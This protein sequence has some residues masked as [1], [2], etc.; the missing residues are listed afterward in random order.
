[1][2]L[3]RPELAKRYPMMNLYTS[4]VKQAEREIIGREHEMRKIK[5][6]MMRPELCNVILLAEAGTGKSNACSSIVPVADERGYIRLGDIKIG[7]KV[8]DENGNPV[9]VIGVF[10]QG[11]QHAYDV[12]FT[13]GSSVIC[14]DE[15]LWAARTRWHHYQ[16][17]PYEVHTL[18]EMMNYGITRTGHRTKKGPQEMKSWYVPRNRAVQ[19]PER[20]F[21]IHPYV[22]GVLLGDGCLTEDALSVSSSDEPVIRRVAEL[23][24]A[25][26]VE[27]SEFCY[28]WKFLKEPRMGV[29][30]VSFFHT[31]EMA[32]LLPGS[33]LFGYKSVERRIPEEYFLGSVEQRMELLH[34]LMDTDGSVSGSEGRVN[35]RFS[36]NN[37]G[38]AADIQKLAASLGYRTSCTTMER[39][40]EIHYNTEYNIYFMVDD[41]TVPELFW[42]QRHKDWVMAHIR[43]DK[44]F[45]RI[46]EDIAI[47]EVIDL[48]REEEMVCIY[49]DCPSHLFQIGECHIVTHNTAL[50][51]GTMIQD[52]KRKYIEVDLSRMLADLS[53]PNEMAT[54]LKTLFDEVSSYVKNHH[55]EIVLFIDE[56]HQIVQLSAAAVEALKPLLADSG[57]RG[58]RVIAAT[59]YIEFQQFVAPNLPLVERLQRINVSQPN[60]ETTVAILK[61][62]AKRYGVDHQFYND[63]VYELIYE[64]TNRYIPASSQPR[65]SIRMMDSM[66]GYHRSEGRRLDAKLLAD[67]IYESEGVNVAFRVDATSI[68]KSLDKRVLS[69]TLATSVIEQ[70]LQICVA[71]LNDKSKPMSSFLFTGS[72][73]TGKGCWDE[74]LVPI[75]TSD[76]SVVKKRHGDLV[77]GDYVFNRKGEP[78]MVTGVYHRGLKDVYRVTL[79]DG[80]SVVV[81]G[82]HLWTWKYAKGHESETYVTTS[83]EDL[84]RRG[85]YRKE[86]NGR[87]SARIWIPM[88]DAVQYSERQYE[89]DPYVLGALL[90]NGCLTIGNSLTFSSGNR[91]V[92]DKIAERIGA[93]EAKQSCKNYNWCFVCG[94][95]SG[96]RGGVRNRLFQRDD[97]LASVPEICGL[98]SHEKFIPEQYKYGSVE[99]RWELVR[100]LFDTDGSIGSCDGDRFNVS[101]STTSS[102]LAY[103]I[104]DLLFSLGI[105]SSVNNNG[106]RERDGDVHDEYQIH[107]KVENDR[108]FLFFSYPKKLALAEKAKGVAKQRYKTFDMV[109]IVSIEKL[110]GQLPTTC[111]MVEDDEHLY[112][113]AE[114][115]TTHNTETVKGLAEILFEDS[116]SLI[117]LDMTE[118]ANDDSLE[119]FRKELTSR[120]WARPYCIILLDEIEKACASVTRILL[121][122]LDDGRL[123]DEHNREVQFTNA[124]IVLTTN[125]GSEIYRNISQYNVDDT[126]SGEQMKRYNK[127]IRASISS[128][129]GDNRFPPELL[130]RIDQIVPFQPLSENTMKAIVKMKLL[131]LK[132]EVMKKHNIKLMIHPNVIRY[133]VEDTLDTDSDSGGARIVMS[134]LETEVTT[135]VARYINLNPGAMVLSVT[136]EGEMAADN[137]YKLLSEAYIKVVSVK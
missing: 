28:T 25:V 109:P 32:R 35:A 102:R 73:G 27:Q 6:A 5:A 58:V 75:Y 92:P 88:N 132:D 2:A 37:P 4:P 114:Y 36:T 34:G 136:V 13:D 74:E 133:L 29:R 26:D 124:Y 1:M 80:R 87:Q 56:F 117:R 84:I 49:V 107:V 129:T 127:L 86:R 46:F 122:V 21:P 10:P 59:T 76:G 67:V 97:V 48:E 130:G 31:L 54:R 45:N 12:R 23:I 90:G 55:Q 110:D 42:L 78:V 77:I 119:R 70:R 50:V 38:L 108:K 131:K 14:N 47:A 106:C 69:Q 135:S 19:R 125:A 61:S 62:Y 113:T 51:Q 8:Y 91:F 81:D 105:A 66:I 9:E 57:T 33:E 101:Y 116:H 123:S 20:T 3:D 39:E 15:H 134:K 65:K 79:G 103:D 120:V 11:M 126:G 137:Q 63:R 22:I 82:S 7:D 104:Q 60:K 18:R 96:P 44:K 41:S 30:D 94:H 121:Q 17:D 72:T 128:T 53:D 43:E 100:G 16:G 99:Q 64:Y 95:D 52:R 40:D 89:L 112:Q 71:D 68:K 85:L 83:T 115:I 111:I 93:I 98:K 118:Y 24:G